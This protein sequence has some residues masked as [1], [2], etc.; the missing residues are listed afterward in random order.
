MNVEAI[1]KKDYIS[2]WFDVRKEMGINDTMNIGG[3]NKLTGDVDWSGFSHSDMDGLG[4]VATLLRGNGY[5]CSKLPVGRDN[6]EPSFFSLLKDN[7]ANKSKMDKHPKKIEWLKTYVCGNDNTAPISTGYFDKETTAIIKHN[8]KRNKVALSTH[9]LWALNKSIS[10]NLLKPDQHYYWFYPVNLRGAVKKEL[11]TDNYSSGVNVC[12][13]NSISPR[14]TQLTIRNKL[15][16]NEYWMTWKLAHIGKLIRKSG[17]KYVYRSLS[18]KNF[19][20]GSFSFLGAWPLKEASNPPE[21]P[22]SVWV[23]CGIGTKNYPV[24]TGVME[25]Y[26]QLT[27]G[28]KLHPWIANNQGVTDRCLSDWKKYL[29]EDMN[30]DA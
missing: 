29:V 11:D 2:M 26:G 22:E 14:E 10:E 5:P 7:K 23:S 3:L 21:N 8:A 9:V 19:Y 24:S 30:H 15:R 1:K 17:V 20:A 6:H 16:S 28:L 18:E 25:W 12:L 13:S 27:L 4:G